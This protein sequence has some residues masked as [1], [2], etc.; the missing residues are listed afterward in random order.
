MQHWSINHVLHFRHTKIHEHCLYGQNHYFVYRV[1]SATYHQNSIFSFGIRFHVFLRTVVYR[2][3]FIGLNNETWILFT[4][5]CFFSIFVCHV[6]LAI[7]AKYP[8]Y[9]HFET[10]FQCS[11]SE[12]VKKNEKNHKNDYFF[13][14]FGNLT[15]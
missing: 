8:S 6:F 12:V 11:G 10:F 13:Q 2:F 9:C 5:P 3:N 14:I 7:R 15:F 1:P 4:L